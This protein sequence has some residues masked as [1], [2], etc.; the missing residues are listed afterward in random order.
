MKQSLAIVSNLNLLESI[1]EQSVA[2][3]AVLEERQSKRLEHE[4]QLRG[5]WALG[6]E[7]ASSADETCSKG[8]GEWAT[9]GDEKCRAR[10]DEEERLAC[11]RK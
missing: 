9:E 1:V 5:E 4:Y 6:H 3:A 2:Y 10:E 8:E 11:C 7:C